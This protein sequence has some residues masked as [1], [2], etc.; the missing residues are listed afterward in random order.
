[1][2]LYVKN[3]RVVVGTSSKVRID[4]YL[5]DNFPIQN[6]LKQGDALSPQFFNFALEYAIRNVQ[7]NQVGLKLNGTQQLLVYDNDMNLLGDN[8]DFFLLL[9]YYGNLDSKH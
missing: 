8:I 2:D 3:S 5:S 4:I 1:M 6:D 7:E 9:H